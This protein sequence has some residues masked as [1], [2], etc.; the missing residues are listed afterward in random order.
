MKYKI[1][2]W[3]DS[4]R[5]CQEWT[6]KEDYEEINKPQE[7]TS[8][9]FV[10]HENESCITLVQNISSQGSEYEQYCHSITIPKRCIKI[11]YEFPYSKSL[12]D[13]EE[14]KAARLRID[15]KLEACGLK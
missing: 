13:E 2:T 1:I 10:L 11:S 6:L 12:M 5:G 8:I 3:V 14:M 15:A 7:I 4:S 9:G